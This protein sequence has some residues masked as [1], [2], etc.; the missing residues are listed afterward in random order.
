[1]Q[2]LENV[3]RKF[4][5]RSELLRSAFTQNHTSNELASRF[6]VIR[7]LDVWS[8]FCRDLILFS[9]AAQCQTAA[10]R[11][12]QPKFLTKHDAAQAARLSAK[13][14]IG[15]EPRWHDATEAL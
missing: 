9:S 11:A 13:G 5:K 8:A 3:K 6:C 2:R 10:G 1:M 7:L 14:K 4:L 12:L 15:Q